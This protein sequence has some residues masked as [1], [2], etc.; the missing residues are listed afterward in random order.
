MNWHEVYLHMKA[1]AALDEAH[2]REI[3]AALEKYP[4]FAMGRMMMAKVATKL[5]DPRAQQ[6][7]FLGSLYA[8]S[9][10]SYAFFLEERMRP[11]VAP[12][13]RLTSSGRESQTPPARS[14]QKEEQS[15]SNEEPGPPEMPFSEAFLPSLQGWVA[16]RRT[17]YQKLGQRLRA[18]LAASSAMFPSAVSTQNESSPVS[19]ELIAPEEAQASSSAETARF[20]Q[21]TTS[22][23]AA[24]VQLMDRPLSSRE[25]STSPHSELTPTQSPPLEPDPL[26][27]SQT[28]RKLPSTSARIPH[29]VAFTPLG[30]RNLLQFELPKSESASVQLLP[31]Q[32]ASIQTES[33]AGQQIPSSTPT[34]PA[35]D[36][37]SATPEAE[38]P[39]LIYPETLREQFH[40]SY[41]P[42]EES[43]ASVH[44]SY[45]TSPSQPVSSTEE[46]SVSEEAA[47]SIPKAGEGF[48]RAYIPLEGVE[49]R[50]HLDSSS[51]SL[52][53]PSSVV[54]KS[55]SPIRSFVP[56]DIDVEASIHLP[57]PEVETTP[58]SEPLSRSSSEG[59]PASAPPSEQK[60]GSMWHSFLAE[61]QK[62]LPLPEAMTQP[63]TRE[64]EGLR[65]EFIRR[66][67]SQRLI[68][69][70]AAP[71]VSDT[72][73][74]DTLIKKLEAFRP[75]APPPER[76]VP[77]LTVPNWEPADTAPRIYT[78][79]MA[80][81]YWSQGD[82]VKAIE[83]YE[84]LI[85]K[86]PQNAEHYRRQIE[87]IRAGE[88]P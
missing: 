47:V 88:S 75:H 52:D 21:P 16:A 42:L 18:Q 30:V 44:L 3:A 41:V 46:S 29:V 87:R 23:E 12:P 72:D 63:A 1:G 5:G 56:L 31:A 80:K 71:S 68:Q 62:E 36:E 15:P 33:P 24:P 11:K 83:V 26:E 65:R 59:E 55:D 20:P 43:H 37:M 82:A 38:T 22:S 13:P 61:L 60:P 28:F 45:E 48:H 19:E 73:L 2:Q 53:A 54:Y 86:N 50:I 39:S 66:L 85:R 84:V 76:E 58:P 79:T 40:R 74:I 64:L 34:S 17:L 69:P 27:S 9:R 67:L 32:A 57:V 70:H 78:E 49:N 14:E 81:L 51:G 35:S 8:P 10:Q 6:L 77:D 7:R 4:F 25:T